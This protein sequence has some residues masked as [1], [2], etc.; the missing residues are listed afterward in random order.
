[1]YR[2][3]FKVSD[4][5]LSCL[6][7]YFNS[8]S[9][10]EDPDSPPSKNLD[11]NGFFIASLFDV[12]IYLQDKTFA[13]LA[14]HLLGEE[15]IAF[16][17]LKLEEVVDQDWLKLCYQNFKPIVVGRFFI[18]SSY[19][20]EI[21]PQDKI[22]LMI[23]AATAFGSGEHQ[24][25]KGCLEALNVILDEL[26]EDIRILDMGCGSGILGLASG[27]V[28]DQSSVLGVDI[29]AKAVDVANHNAA[30]NKVQNF[31]AVTSDGFTALNAEPFHLLIANILAKPLINLAPQMKASALEGA[32]IILSGLLMRQKDDVVNAYLKEGFTFVGLI[33]IDDWASVILKA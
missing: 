4:S 17:N 16:S 18:H 30:L 25:T 32:Y 28:K 6:E 12:E 7:P 26:P 1:M 2:L 3:S 33:E 9:I 8:F 15:D 10:F 21:V 24:T 19:A 13:A 31:T 29:D 22:G 5:D 11:D 27:C 23:D 20:P 14:E